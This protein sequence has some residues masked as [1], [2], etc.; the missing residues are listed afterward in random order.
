L[1]RLYNNARVLTHNAMEDAVD[2][3]VIFEGILADFEKMNIPD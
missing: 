1:H 2:Q 3:A